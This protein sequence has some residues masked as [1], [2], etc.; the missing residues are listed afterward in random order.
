MNEL[1]D[2]LSV[3]TTTRAA[4]M[5][6]YLLLFVSTAAGMMMSLKMLNG[7]PKAAMLAAHQWSGWFGFL[8]SFVHG[9]VLLFDSYVGFSLYELLIPFA[10]DSNR[11]LTGFGTL[12]F[13]CTLLLLLSSDFIKKLGRKTWRA[14]HFL[15]FPAFFLALAHGLLMGTDSQQ[16]WAYGMYIATGGLMII[17]TG[18]RIAAVK[19]ENKP[20]R[21]LHKA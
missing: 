5:T 10:S 7:K 20:A 3:W 15:A 4:G 21:S 18:L 9:G 6:A 16:G 11:L 13:Y 1:A 2:T 8:F 17:F 19:L 14:I 12:A